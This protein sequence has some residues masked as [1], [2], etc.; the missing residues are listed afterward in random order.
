MKSE[1]ILIR[2]GDL[3]LK[4]KNKHTF[5]KQVRSLLKEKMKKLEVKFLFQHDRIYIDFDEKIEKQ[6]VKQLSYVSGIQSYS[7]VYQTTN[8]L[9]DILETAKKILEKDIKE[10]V[11]FKIE[12]KRADKLYPLTSQEITREIAPRLLANFDHLLKV[13]VKNPEKTLHIEVRKE[14]TYLYMETLKAMGGF[15]V[16]IGGKGLLMLSGGIDSPVAGYLAM[17]QGIAIELFHFESTPLTPLE[18]VQKVVDLAKVLS[19][20]MPNTTIKL[21]LV[22]FRETHEAILKNVSDPYIINIMRRMMYRLAERYANLKDILCIINGESVGQVASQ[23]LQSI[24]TVENVT[25]IPIL[26]PLITNDK[27]EIIKISKDI[28][29]YDISIRAFNDC[30]TVYVPK[31]PIIRPTVEDALKEESK[32]DYEPLLEE[33]LKNIQTLR[34]NPDTDFVI[35]EH[36]FEV[37]DAIKAYKEEGGM[38]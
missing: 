20:Y 27:Q 15:P 12:T 8:N 32:F 24:K 3:V 9:D 18:S 14:A 31:N 33:A 13:D 5:I 1:K 28:E 26:R 10:K 23:T 29:S 6:V 25:N 2:F 11:R 30:C 38:L 4:G 36:G 7:F 35:Y 34:I 16:G 22:P 21:H 37:T 19:R 17:K